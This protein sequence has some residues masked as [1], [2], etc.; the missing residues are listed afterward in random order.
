MAS[1]ALI[2]RMG[3]G[4]RD[5]GFRMIARQNVPP[6]AMAMAPFKGAGN[7]NCTKSFAPQPT[8]LQSDLRTKLKLPPAAMAETPESPAGTVTWPEP[9]LP[10]ATIVPSDLRAR[11]WWSPEAIAVTP[12]RPAW[13]LV[14]P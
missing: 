7:V 14:W 8:R 12:D 6:P 1:R 2:W 9:L 5:Q 10:Q 4:S 11:L 13:T 3:L